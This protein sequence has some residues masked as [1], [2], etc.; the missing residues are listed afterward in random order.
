MI[1]WLFFVLAVAALLMLGVEW[2]LRRLGIRRVDP[3]RA[4]TGLGELT[5]LIR[6]HRE[7]RDHHE[8]R[9]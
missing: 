5:R 6:Q 8:H 3:D 7:R 9:D 2:L 4:S 1:A